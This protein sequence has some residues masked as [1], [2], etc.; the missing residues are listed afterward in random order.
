MPRLASL[1]SQSMAGLGITRGPKQLMLQTA[2]NNPNAFGTVDNDQFGGTNG[3]MDISGDRLIIGVADEDYNGG[4]ASGKAYIF[5]T[6]SAALVHTLDNPNPFGTENL[7]AFGRVVGIDG[8][9]AVVAAAAEDESAGLSSGKVYVYNVT[10][11]ALTRTIDNPN[12]QT[13]D[14]VDEF[15]TFVRISGTTVIASARLEDDANTNS[16][17]AYLINSSTGNTIAT[18][19]NPSAFGTSQNDQFGSTTAID[20]NYCVVTAQTESGNDGSFSGAA[21]IFNSTTGSLLQ[22]LLNPAAGGNGFFDFFGSAS[23]ISGNYVAIGAYGTEADGNDRSGVVYI[24]ETTNGDYSNISLKHTLTNPN[25]SGTTFDDRFGVSLAMSGNYL[26]VGAPHE[27]P[28]YRSGKAYLY[29]V[30]SGNLLQT[31]DNPNAYSIEDDD[32][33]GYSVA[34]DGDVVAIGALREDEVA[35][36]NSGKVYIYNLV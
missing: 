19:D 11:G 32:N 1:T 25:P 7:D 5:N 22:S 16:G 6:T 34:M 33:F 26:V 12:A 31:I 18:I 15:G 3:T 24:Y 21:Y 28:T 27:G 20:G 13:T 2:L 23:D 4:T 10:T 30:I 36:T 8:N 14:V 9:I 17:K 35:G 29:D